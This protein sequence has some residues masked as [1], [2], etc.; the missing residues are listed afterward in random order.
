MCYESWADDAV[1]FRRTAF[2]RPVRAGTQRAV[3]ASNGVDITETEAS[4]RDTINRRNAVNGR[5]QLQFALL[6]MPVAAY[7][8]SPAAAAQ[9]PDNANAPASPTATVGPRNPPLAA[10][11][12]A[13]M[14]G[15]DER[16]VRLTLE[17]LQIAEGRREEET[18]LANLC[19]GYLRLRQFESALS[20]CDQL[21]ERNENAWRAYNSRAMVYLELEEYA[22]A[23]ADLKR[24]EAIAPA[25]RTV[26]VARQLYMDTVHPVAPEVEIDDR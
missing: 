13:F 10:G 15:D 9:Q 25:S 8:I 24:A 19:T 21:I 20:Y 23:D 12:E 4:H 5:S 2:A 26:K 6:L 18:A 11:A 16:G 1:D 3:L 22:K 7:L 14:A 17:G